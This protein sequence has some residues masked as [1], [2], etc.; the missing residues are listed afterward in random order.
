MSEVATA[1]HM[2]DGVH[3]VRACDI[4]S[5]VDLCVAHARYEKAAYDTEGKASSLH[6]ALFMTP[7]RL[8]A[9][10]AWQGSLPI[11]YATASVEFS[12]F[13][14]C[15]YLHM[16]CLFVDADTRG[17]G[18]GQTLLDAVI[19]KAR[20]L[21]LGEIQWQ[22]PEWNLGAIRFYVRQGATAKLKQRFVLTV[23]SAS[24]ASS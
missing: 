10:L 5:L 22:T 23:D 19:A 11:G 4:P 18:I 12:T 13:T 15:E 24:P 17:K 3:P 14:G 20:G 9:W 8:Y 1:A 21:G 2:K 16:D 7:A 6:R